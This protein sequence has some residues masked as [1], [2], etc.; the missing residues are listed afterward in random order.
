MTGPGLE[1]AAMA[2]IV[3]HILAQVD[4]FA[5]LQGSIYGKSSLMIESYVLASSIN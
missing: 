1:V 2:N 4:W 3:R 5:Y